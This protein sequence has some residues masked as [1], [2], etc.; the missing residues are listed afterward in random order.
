MIVS[1]FNISKI[2][3]VVRVVIDGAV[4]DHLGVGV[5][6]MCGYM[7]FSLS[8]PLSFFSPKDSYDDLVD[9]GKPLPIQRL[10]AK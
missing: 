1:H 6:A 7:G 4:N 2:F 5:V 3:Q 10:P 9:V 8:F